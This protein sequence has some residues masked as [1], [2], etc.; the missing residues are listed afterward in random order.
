MASLVRLFCPQPLACGS[1]VAIDRR[2]AHYLQH[3]M[4][5]VAGDRLRLFNGESGEFTGE[6]ARFNRHGAEVLLGER[7][8]TPLPEQTCILSFALVKRSATDLI[9]EKA[10]ELGATVI[11]P[12]VTSYTQTIRV[13]LE[14]LNAIAAEATE[15]CERLSVPVIRDVVT[16]D[17]LLESWPESRPLFVAA[18]RV[19]ASPL[20]ACLRDCG[21]L[22][23]PEGGFTVGELD[24]LGRHPFVTLVSLGPRILRAETAVIA[25][26]ARLLADHRPS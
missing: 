14:R 22:V 15:Q 18:E 2:Q 11:Q 7:L 13:N 24:V 10:T 17:S 20:A 9:V 19:D 6:I 1:V 23:G 16:I 26:L 3:V 21:L 4:R 12:V 5:R 25:G 8:R